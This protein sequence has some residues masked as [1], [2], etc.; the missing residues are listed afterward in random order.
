[1]VDEL[2]VRAAV[3]AHP[4]VCE[5]FTWGRRLACVVVDIHRASP[6]LLEELLAEAWARKAPRQLVRDVEGL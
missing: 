4:E 3:A 1:M 6:R 2:G 5:P